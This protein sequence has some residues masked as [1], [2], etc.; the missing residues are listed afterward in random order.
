ML[1]VVCALVLTFSRGAFL[2]F[3]MVNGLFIVTR[4]DPR[5]FLFGAVVVS[6]L[7]FL[8]PGT[9]WDRVTAGLGGDMNAVTAGRTGEIWLPLLPELWRSPFI[10][11]GLSSILWSD[12]MRAERILQ[13]GHAHSAYL[14]TLLDMGIIGLVLLLAFF[15]LLLR[16]FWRASRDKSLSRTMRGFFEGASVGLLAFLM[17]GFA[18]STLTPCAEQSFLWLAAGMLYGMRRKHAKRAKT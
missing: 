2:G 12:A 16:D 1:L 17:A 9:M 8:L 7:L 3:I 10:G 6:G 18:G 14:Q 13:V 15:G 4:R 5:G 11:N